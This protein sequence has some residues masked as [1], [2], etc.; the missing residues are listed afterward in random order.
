VLG[1]NNV[2][3]TLG[4]GAFGSVMMGKKMVESSKWSS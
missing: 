4:E 2:E 1:E 3:L